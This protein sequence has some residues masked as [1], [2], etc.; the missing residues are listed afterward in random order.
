VS[1]QGKSSKVYYMQTGS[2][3]PLNSET[4]AA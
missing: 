2:N 1:A 3:D 4:S